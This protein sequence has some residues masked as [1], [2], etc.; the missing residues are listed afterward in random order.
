[1]DAREAYHRRAYRIALLL[2]DSE[3]AALR[4]LER[5]A[6]AIPQPETTSDARFDRAVIQ[7]SRP[8]YESLKSPEN[9]ALAGRFDLSEDAQRLWREAHALEP[10]VLEAWVLR[11]V[12][13]L[14]EVRAA[15]AMDC[16]RNALEKIHLVS[17]RRTLTESLGEAY[18]P[19]LQRLTGVLDTLDT[20][21]AL[22][23]IEGVLRAHKARSRRNALIGVVL[24]LIAF[25]LMTY[26]LFDLLA[27][28]DREDRVRDAASSAFSNPIPQMPTDNDAP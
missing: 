20:A 18:S 4:I 16:S 12:E 2:T 10:Q 11:D 6:R 21:H 17:A 5:V 15:R 28:N 19:A 24:L 8:V 3:D 25:G 7:A 26:V 23:H 22:A 9:L 27:W 13:G 1:M 14:D